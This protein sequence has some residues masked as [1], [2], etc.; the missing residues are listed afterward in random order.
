MQDAIAI[1]ISLAAAAWLA[2]TL[3]RQ[4]ASPSCGKASLSSGTDGFVP[5]A[6]VTMN[7]KKPGRSAERPGS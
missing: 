2:R 1:A 6:D 4:M 3:W 7:I 5:I